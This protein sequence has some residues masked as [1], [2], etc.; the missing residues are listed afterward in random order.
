MTHLR[1]PLEFGF[2]P[3]PAADD[4]AT[5]LRLAAVADAAGLELLTMQ[6]NPYQR[7]FLDT[8]TLLSV[9]G[10]RT[11]RIRLSP[12]VA[13]LPLRPP[14]VLAKSAA[15][16]DV[17]T[18]GRVELGLGAGA[19]WDAVV[20]AG[21][22]RRT[23][24]EAVDAI[25]EAIALIREFWRGDTVHFDGDFYSADGLHAGPK[26]AHDIPIWLGAIGPRML[27]LTG[28]V[29][30]AWVPSMA[31]VPPS[32]LAEKNQVID[33]AAV[34]AGRD[35]A[36][37]KRIYNINGSFGQG[38][39]LLEGGVRDW[40]EQLADLTLGLGMSTFILATDDADDLARFAGDVAPAVREL[41]AA[42][43]G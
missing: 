16:L 15:S 28:S 34:A 41:V 36:S 22:P 8:W 43:R 7:R 26:P 4:L 2:F 30:D 3:S 25:T 27:R 35:P 10:A 31:F 6:D 39:G 37:V 9:I 20:A 21:G 18:G 12:N 33:D 11:E 23:P 40:A 42:E 14:V 1:Q 32:Q 13:N 38:S 5:T 19:F 29:A 24:R 17:I